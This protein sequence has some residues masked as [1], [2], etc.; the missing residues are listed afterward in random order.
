MRG[1]G[2]G[3]TRPGSKLPTGSRR[4]GVVMATRTAAWRS[5][6]GLLSGEGPRPAVPPGSGPVTGAVPPRSRLGRGHCWL[7]HPQI[8]TL[9][10]LRPSCLTAWPSSSGG[11]DS[12]FMMLSRGAPWGQPPAPEASSPRRPSPGPASLPP[13]TCGRRRLSGAWREA[14][15]PRPGSSLAQDPA[16][17]EIPGA[18]RVRGNLSLEIQA[19]ISRSPAGLECHLHMQF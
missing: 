17:G 19:Q 12:A 18:G 13:G 9:R 7:G 6:V 2:H 3:A 1:N 4:E 8:A 16:R 14:A 15:A 10:V 5:S 11:S